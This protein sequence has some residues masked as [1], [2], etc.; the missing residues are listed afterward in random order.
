MP[1]MHCARTA[2]TYETEDMKKVIAG[3]SRNIFI[4][5]TEPVRALIRKRCIPFFIKN[6]SDICKRLARLGITS[7]KRATDLPRAQFSRPLSAPVKCASPKMLSLAATGHGSP[8][9]ARA[10]A[11][12]LHSPSPPSGVGRRS[13]TRR[14]GD[15]CRHVTERPAPRAGAATA[16]TA[17]TANLSRCTPSCRPAVP[18][19]GRSHVPSCSY[20]VR[21]GPALGNRNSRCE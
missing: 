1:N 20:G 3:M 13:L 8:R 16:P 7:G 18:A 12:D 4:S 5:Q 14:A 19:S 6:T 11:G 21:A 10:G 17:P 9:P 15:T 2:G